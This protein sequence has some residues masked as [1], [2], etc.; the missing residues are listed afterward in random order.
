MHSKEIK[1]KIKVNLKR[2]LF[3]D[4][5]CYQRKPKIKGFYI[6]HSILYSKETKMKTKEIKNWKGFLLIFCVLK[7]NQK[8]IK[9]EKIFIYY[10]LLH[11]N[12][13]KYKL[14]KFLFI[15]LFYAER[16]QMFIE[17]IFILSI[18]FALK[19]NQ[20][21]NERNMIRLEKVFICLSPLCSNETKKK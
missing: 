4:I 1:N 14:K 5:F 7:K 16:N 12:E 11:L 3:V 13:T 21:E 20:K 10:S 17:N 6:Y 15:I 8:E 18:T 9:F 19:W 2:F